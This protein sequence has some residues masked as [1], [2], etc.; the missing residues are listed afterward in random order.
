MLPA[1]PACSFDSKRE[2]ANFKT[3]Q[4]S[5]ILCTCDR[6]GSLGSTLE[7]VGKVNTPPDWSCEVIIVDN[8][9][10]KEDVPIANGGRLPNAMRLRCLRERRKGKSRALNTALAQSGG[11]ILVFIDDDV[12]PACDWLVKICAPIVDGR[13]DAVA[14]G[15]RLPSHLDRPWMNCCQRAWLACTDG[16]DPA[17]PSRMVGA[18]MAF[19]RAVLA[20]VPA[21]DPEL[22]GGA[23]G[24]GEDTLFSIQL[25]EA[26]YRIVGAFDALVEHHFDEKRLEREAWVTAAEKMGRADAYLAYHWEHS[27]WTGPWL[28]L[29]ASWVR[30]A[31]YRFLHFREWSRP[32]QTPGGLINAIRNLHA[33]LH[34]LHERRR[35]RNYVRRGLVRLFA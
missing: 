9:S 8:G 5:I 14:G 33:L 20:R 26:G 32:N 34:Y 7:A 21:F 22:G 10:G 23:L 18:N 25:R 29:L 11:D 31:R 2:P 35:P 30:L 13:A 1:S 15:I 19:S 3:V 6:A 4:V 12:R 24:A 16:L 27:L 17:D 28:S